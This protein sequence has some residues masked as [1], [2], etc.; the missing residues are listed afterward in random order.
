MAGSST[1][2]SSNM[3]FKWRAHLCDFT[4]MRAS[5]LRVGCAREEQAMSSLLAASGLEGIFWQDLH[6]R[7]VVN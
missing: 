5:P 2:P 6:S 1:L 4:V 7:T 3:F